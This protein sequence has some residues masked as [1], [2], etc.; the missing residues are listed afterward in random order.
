MLVCDVFILCDRRS[1]ASL[2]ARPIVQN[3]DGCE[4]RAAGH[5]PE[6]L[7]LI[8]ILLN[9]VQSSYFSRSYGS[10]P[11]KEVLECPHALDFPSQLPSWD[12]S[13]AAP[14]RPGTLPGPDG[15][16]H[17]PMGPWASWG[18]WEP[19]E[20]MGSRDES[21]VCVAAEY[22]PMGTCSRTI[23]IQVCP[24]MWPKFIPSQSNAKTIILCIPQLNSGVSL[25]VYHVEVL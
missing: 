1:P 8:S 15:P 2:L 6:I 13:A 16:M 25:G 23:R 21:C 17:G 10:I 11:L 3:A 24:Q 19:M 12:C 7:P 22:E 5:C 14:L 4:G 9:A 18:P 20:P